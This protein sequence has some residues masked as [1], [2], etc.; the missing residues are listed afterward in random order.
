[1]RS[2]KLTVTLV[3][4][5]C[6]CL[7][8]VGG[9]LAYIVAEGT[10]FDNRFEPATVACRAEMAKEGAA[11]RDLAVTNTGAISAYVRATLVVTFVSEADGA[12][13]HGTAPREGVDYA[14]G[15][16]SGHWRLGSDGFYYY[17]AAVLP[18][19]STDVLLSAITP[20]GTPPDGYRLQVDFLASAIQAEPARAVN[21][22]W[23]ATVLD[24]GHITPP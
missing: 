4:L 22:A 16:G 1:M 21:E 2:K 14:V 20:L 17:A 6:L 8:A 24:N 7:T 18:G 9:T 15:S 13:T 12:T 3:C 19:E 5:L 23:G 10:P 11:Y